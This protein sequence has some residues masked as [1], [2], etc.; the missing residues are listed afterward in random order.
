MRNETKWALLTLCAVLLITGVTGYVAYRTQFVGF[1]TSD[2]YGAIWV[3]PV[4]LEFYGNPGI[5]VNGH[6]WIF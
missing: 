1:H 3:G 5:T 4:S 6:T 2:D